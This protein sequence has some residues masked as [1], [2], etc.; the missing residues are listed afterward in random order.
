M[1]YK[2]QEKA[3]LRRYRPEE[4]REVMEFTQPPYIVRTCQVGDTGAMFNLTPGFPY[5][6]T[7]D[8]LE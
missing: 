5:H 1:V 7:L 2:K 6:T 3:L 8:M 4:D